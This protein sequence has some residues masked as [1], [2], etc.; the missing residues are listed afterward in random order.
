MERLRYPKDFT[1]TVV[2][3]ISIH[4]L[5]IQPDRI[6]IKKVL[7]NIGSDN[8]SMLMKIQMADVLSQ[9]SYHQQEKIDKLDKVNSIFRDIMD[10]D[11]CFSLKYL[12]V[13]GS[14]LMGCGMSK[15][16]IIGDTLNLLLNKVIE[17]TLINDKETL[18]QYVRK[19]VI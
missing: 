17:N 15:G 7:K 16:K 10:N 14:D 1:E 5:R 3:L 6:I 4:D 8:F 12:K 13:N 19:N 18:L 9:S 2:N 11:E